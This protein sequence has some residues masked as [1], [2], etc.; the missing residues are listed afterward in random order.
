MLHGYHECIAQFS[1]LA[2][3]FYQEGYNVYAPRR[4]APRHGTERSTRWRM[5]RCERTNWRG[6]PARRWA[7]FP[8]ARAE[9]RDHGS[10][11]GLDQG[12]D[13][14]QHAGQCRGGGLAGEQFRAID[15]LLRDPALPS[16]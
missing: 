5:R 11:A 14:A 10:G 9:R 1:E 12:I 3:R 13:E 15:D 8:A 16:R 6:T 2:A 7:L 4:A